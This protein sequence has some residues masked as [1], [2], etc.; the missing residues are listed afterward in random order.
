MVTSFQHNSKLA[1]HEPSWASMDCTALPADA[2]A[3]AKTFPHHWIR[4][5]VWYLHRG[6]LEAAWARAATTGQLFVLAHL[7]KHFAELGLKTTT[8]TG[9]VFDV[10][11]FDLSLMAAGILVSEDLEI[12]LGAVA[13][14]VTGGE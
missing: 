2:F 11:E 1:K 13:L 5:D 14:R 9:V 10:T 3:F 8:I 4:A 7:R 12:D 6:G